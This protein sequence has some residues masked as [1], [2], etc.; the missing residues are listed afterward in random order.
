MVAPI[1]KA[2]LLRQVRS[3]RADWDALVASIPR[4]RLTESGLP[5]GWSVK[6]VIAHIVWDKR[7]GVALVRARALVGSE[8]WRLGEDER[9]AAVHAQ[10]R[11]RS[12][13]DVLDEYEQV[14]ADYV[15]ALESLSED[16][17]NDPSHFAGM[18]SDWRPWRVLYDPHHYAH[19]AADVRAWLASR[20]GPA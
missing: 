19:H 2:D 1:A 13:D 20:P 14:L 5:G 7:E 10:N 18:P 3:A 6:D 11:D 17:L 12:L 8:L 15:A 9:N 16:E 4:E